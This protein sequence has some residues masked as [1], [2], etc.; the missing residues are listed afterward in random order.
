M[1]SGQEVLVTL[2]LWIQGEDVKSGDIVEV[3][4][5]AWNRRPQCAEERTHKD[6]VGSLDDLLGGCDGVVA[7]YHV[8]RKDMDYVEMGVLLRDKLLGFVEGGGFGSAV[9]V[10]DVCEWAVSGWDS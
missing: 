2:H 6:P 4:W 5:S 3:D 10:D 8:E 9:G 7:A 1:R